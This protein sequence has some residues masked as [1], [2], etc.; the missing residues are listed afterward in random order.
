MTMML[1]LAAE[2]AADAADHLVRRLGERALRRRLR[3]ASSFLVSLP[4]STLLVQEEG[5]EVG[6]HDRWPG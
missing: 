6:D 1:R 2:V 4:A 3:P 5:V